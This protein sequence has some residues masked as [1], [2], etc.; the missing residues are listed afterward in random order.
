MAGVGGQLNLMY[1]EE[2]CMVSLGVFQPLQK[3][4]VVTVGFPALLPRPLPPKKARASL[5]PH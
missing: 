4:Q 1:G 2:D 3:E 5:R